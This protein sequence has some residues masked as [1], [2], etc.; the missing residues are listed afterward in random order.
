MTV[1]EIFP[2]IYSYSGRFMTRNLVPGSK[3]YG[4]G[5]IVLDNVE[6]RYWD[7]FRSKLS[8]AI[9][10][11]LKEMPIEKDNVVLYLGSSEGTTVS[12]ISDIVGEKGVV[13]GV[14]ISENVMRKFVYLCESRKNLVPVLEDAN[15][16]ENY[17][18]HLSGYKVDV[19]YQDISQRNQAEIF[20]KNARAFL[21]SGKYGILV[22]K[23][24]SI[25]STTNPKNIYKEEIKKLENLF[26]ILQIVKLKPFEKD[27]LLVLCRRK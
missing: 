26:E 3:V 22:I 14:D 6:Y 19:I 18:E 16:P 20:L 4:E 17:K 15:K 10:N 5:V 8:T 27:H 21:S 12:H 23:A 7:H 9:K 2:G 24:R 1:E 13:F 25:S 11:G